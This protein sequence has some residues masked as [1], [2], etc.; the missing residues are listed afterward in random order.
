MCNLSNRY[1]TSPFSPGIST[2]PRI[3]RIGWLNTFSTRTSTLLS[4]QQ[5]QPISVVVCANPISRT[6][7]IPYP[8]RSP[9]PTTPLHLKTSQPT[10]PPTKSPNRSKFTNPPLYQCL[11]VIKVVPPRPSPV[12]MTASAKPCSAE[13]NQA[14]S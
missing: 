11:Q 10:I 3:I 5:I 9:L 8:N 12:F 6:V 7:V 4:R 14:C 13:R 2:F 1:S